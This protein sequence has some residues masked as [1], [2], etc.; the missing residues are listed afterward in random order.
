MIDPKQI[1]ENSLM[2]IVAAIHGTL[3]EFYAGKGGKL[4]MYDS[5]D[6]DTAFF[7]TLEA[8]TGRRE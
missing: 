4:R 5:P 8:S 1:P 7:D 3:Q 2:D 6:L